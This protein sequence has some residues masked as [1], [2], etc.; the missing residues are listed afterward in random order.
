MRRP[1]G[2][3]GGFQGPAA[4]AASCSFPHRWASEDVECDDALTSPTTQHNIFFPHKAAEILVF[5]LH[6]AY[7]NI[8]LYFMFN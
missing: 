6:V 7:F 3:F 5:L 4:A 8:S 2:Y 1:R